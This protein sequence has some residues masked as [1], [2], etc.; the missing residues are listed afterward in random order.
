MYELLIKKDI[1]LTL[2]PT[3][4]PKANPPLEQNK[5]ISD[6]TAKLDSNHGGSDPVE[7]HSDLFTGLGRLRNHEYS[8]SISQEVA[9]V[10][11][12]P[13]KTPHKLRDKIRA[14]LERMEELGVIERVNLITDVVKMM[15]DSPI[16]ATDLDG[17]GK[18]A[19]PHKID[20]TYD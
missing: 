11:C 15:N 2:G 13:L 5:T 16:L 3:P 14:E 1:S 7:L 17:R 12:P 18:Q 19:N 9:P 4:A 10:K 8:I 6:S 20:R